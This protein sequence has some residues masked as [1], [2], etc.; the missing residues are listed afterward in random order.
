MVEG[1]SFKV[2][3]EGGCRASWSGLAFWQSSIQ[4]VTTE[5]EQR[6]INK[7]NGERTS[8]ADSQSARTELALAISMVCLIVSY[9][10]VAKR[11]MGRQVRNRRI[12]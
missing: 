12:R 7:M 11:K 4:Y 2:G 1:A 3:D 8:G 5:N 6:Y 10:P 9:A